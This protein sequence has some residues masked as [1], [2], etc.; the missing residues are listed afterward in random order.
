MIRYSLKCDKDHRFE[1]W[2]ASA[3]KFEDLRDSG[4]L[5]CAVCGSPE[6]DRAMMAPSVASGHTPSEEAAAPERPLSQPASPAEQA[7]REL[8]RKIEAGTEDVG[9]NFAREARAIHEGEKPNRAIRGEARPDEAKELLRDG[10]EVVPLPFLRGS[11][12]N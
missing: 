5:A 1:S 6:V 7:L 9:R 4:R 11:K 3:E 8:R 2:F 10:I 12:T